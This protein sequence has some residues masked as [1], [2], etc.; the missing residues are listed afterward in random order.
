M[1]K[2]TDE[3]RHAVSLSDPNNDLCERPHAKLDR[4][5]RQSHNE[6][7]EVS[8]GGVIG[9]TMGLFKPDQSPL[10]NVRK[11]AEPRAPLQPS[12]GMALKMDPLLQEALFK[13][14]ARG[15]VGK[16]EVKS[17]QGLRA[18]SK[19]T[20]RKKRDIKR[21]KEE[22]KQEIKEVTTERRKD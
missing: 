8:G 19:Q 17:W 9:S 15:P 16:A 5:K 4:R 10:K 21:K 12:H 22:S 1:D 20:H 2:I 11:D 13:G 7:L 18:K 6:R 3:Q 14:V